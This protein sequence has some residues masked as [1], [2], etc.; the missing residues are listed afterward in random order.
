M[1]RLRAHTGLSPLD[2]LQ[3]RSPTEVDL[4]GEP[5]SLV[6]LPEGHLLPLLAQD[7]DGSCIF[8]RP[9]PDGRAVCSVHDARP[10]S[11]RAYPFDRPTSA[12]EDLGLHPGALCPPETGHLRVLSEVD[13]KPDWIAT[14]RNR[15]RELEMHA[16]SI[17]R[18]NQRQRLRLRLGKPR[19]SATEFFRL[20][21]DA[22]ATQGSAP[23]AP[24]TVLA[25]DATDAT[26]VACPEQVDVNE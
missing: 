1:Q 26:H 8:L 11:C 13:Q 16:Q 9:E 17:A 4:E 18:W 24:S 15:D 22:F 21:G 12:S 3:L 20:L 7:S 5:E 6:H 25:E 23:R 19:L 2:F 14:V 10:R